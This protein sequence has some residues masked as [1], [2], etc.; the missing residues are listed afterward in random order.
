MGFLEN[1]ISWGD[2]KLI[3]E[4]SSSIQG[5]MTNIQKNLWKQLAK[6]A[7]KFD[8]DKIQRLQVHQVQVKLKRL[9]DSF[10]EIHQ[11]YLHYRGVDKDESKET[12]IV[13]EQEQHYE[14]GM[15]KL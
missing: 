9:E 7:G 12:T 8:H 14:E 6:C 10:D 2:S 11:V 3:L 4:K 15:I 5:M 13:E 1:V